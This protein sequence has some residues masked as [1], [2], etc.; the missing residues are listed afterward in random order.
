MALVL[1]A[2]WNAEALYLW[3]Q[4]APIAPYT[5]EDAGDA[6]SGET[7]RGVAGGRRRRSGKREAVASE[8]RPGS[9][10]TSVLPCQAQVLRSIIGELLED[11]LL[12]SVAVEMSIG[13]WLPADEAGRALAAGD[14]SGAAALRRFE[15]PALRFT[16]EQAIDLL[17]SV[18]QDLGDQTA[19]LETSSEP[20][21][22]APSLRYWAVL[23]RFCMDLIARRQFVPQVM[24]GT[25]TEKQ[26]EV[27]GPRSKPRW[28]D[29]E[30]EEPEQAGGYVASWRPVVHDRVELE[31]LERFAGA[32]PLACLA[33][34]SPPP[35]GEQTMAEAGRLVEQFLNRTAD[36]VIRR[37]VADDPFFRTAAQQSVQPAAPPETKLMAALL[38]KDPVIN[39]G[40]SESAVLLQQV[41]GWA[42]RLEPSNTTSNLQLTFCLEEPLEPETPE[43]D[44]AGEPPDDAPLTDEMSVPEVQTA[45]PAIVTAPPGPW[46]VRL[47]LHPHDEPGQAIELSDLWIE[48][49]AAILGRHLKSRRAHF[50]SE[51]ARAAEVFPPAT[52]L[53]VQP[54]PTALELNTSEAYSFIRQWGPQLRD[55]GFGVSL[56]AWTTRGTQSLGLRLLV[57]PMTVEGLDDAVEGLGARRKGGGGFELTSGNFGLEAL[58]EFDWQIAVG[59]M[60]LSMDKLRDL[61][62]VNSPLVRLGGQWVQIDTGATRQALDFVVQQHGRKMTL[63]QALRH[64]YGAT[65]A[66]TGLPV[67]GM[68]G[69]DWI[70]QLLDQSP[71]ARLGNFEQPRDFVG[72]LRAYQLRGLHWLVFLDRLGIGACLADDMGLGKTI[73]LIALLLHERQTATTDS[74]PP[75]PGPTL[76]FAPTSVVGNWVREIERF[77]P[78][79]R[80]MVHHGPLR[81]TGAEFVKAASAADVVITS[82]PL[83]H[84]DRD[85]LARIPWH[86][87]TLDEA[88]K[89]KN[90][91]AAATIAIRSLN[92]GRRVALTGTPIENHLSELWSI[93]EVLNPG[94][95]GPAT[96]F[97]ERFAVP[98]EKLGEKDRSEQLRKMIRPFVLRRLKSDP[99]IAGDLPEKMEAKVF[100][101]LT[102]EQASLYEHFVGQSLNQIDAS[103][104]IRRRGLILAVLTRLKQICDHPA[105]ILKESSSYDRRS[106]KSERLIEMLEEVIDGGD[107]ALIFTQFRQMGHVLEQMIA[108]RLRV[109]VQFLHGGTPTKERDAMI[110]RFQQGENGLRIF[111]LSLRAGGL[112]LNLTAANHVFHFDRWWNPAVESQATDRAHRVGQTR[113]VQVHKFVCIGTMEERIDRMLS[114]KM[115]L[116]DRIIGSGDQWLTDLSTEQ[117]RSYLTLSQEAVAEF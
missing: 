51:L 33:Q 44:L 99:E 98:I 24:E 94:L 93:M 74:S 11:S 75:S 14:S 70:A 53:L 13:L 36:A 38:E 2:T 89:I 4:C 59:D 86:R 69:T 17:T 87:L 27:A 30:I 76:L 28:E 57:A 79:L 16:P 15:V 71:A 48:S 26:A 56:P 22:C 34:I 97:R 103:S 1:H 67:L 88:Q 85:E 41:Q 66:E 20:C 21:V 35:A 81:L 112:G 10:P 101:N 111:I 32:M 6:D 39:A 29:D 42:G 58:L 116:A 90:P 77:S 80:V 113:K 7:A 49:D 54:R 37:S 43:A 60:N 55:R 3:G 72:T 8:V 100:C 31:W 110:E 96:E 45:E 50:M 107:A 52:G 114:E 78:S 47:K 68:G 104:G 117:L 63:A 109:P 83:A 92:A 23:A 12:G 19:R 91:S 40:R 95:L 73:Q 105:L 108:Q 64:V 25:G 46:T 9:G 5:G 82:Y 62:G 102:S 106:G 18:P 61:A 65:T 115:A 84:R